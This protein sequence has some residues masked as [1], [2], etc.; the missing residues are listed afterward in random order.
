MKTMKTIFENWGR[1]L[2]HGE[3]DTDVIA[4]VIIFNEDGKVLALKRG[5]TAPKYPGYWDL[6]GGHVQEGED[7]I[8]GA[9]RETKEE[10]GLDIENLKEIDKHKKVHFLLTREYSG[11]II[12]DMPEHSGKKWITIDDLDTLEFPPGGKTAL[13]KAFKENEETVKENDN[14][15]QDVASTYPAEKRFLVGM[16]GNDTEVGPGLEKPS[17]KA[18]ASS[19]PGAAG[20]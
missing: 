20:G 19:P 10:S 2:E 6:P 7:I 14:F 13:T 18:P 11:E 17:F 3:N 5:E 12:E 4:K 8:Q 9:T 16:G 15:Q 1:F